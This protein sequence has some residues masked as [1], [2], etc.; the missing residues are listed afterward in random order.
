M[1]RYGDGPENELPLE[2]T[3]DYTRDIGYLKIAEYTVNV[4]NCNSHNNLLNNVWY[5]PEEVFPVFGTPEDRQHIFWVPVDP[6]Y[7]AIAKK[8]EVIFKIINS[9]IFRAVNMSESVQ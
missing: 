7:Y 2:V 4:T 5:Q 3:G 9:V 6:R 8:L 1:Q